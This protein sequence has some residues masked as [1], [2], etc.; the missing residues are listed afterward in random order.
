LGGPGDAWFENGASG[1]LA[2]MAAAF[3][4]LLTGA[5]GERTLLNALEMGDLSG[6]GGKVYIYIYESFS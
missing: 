1:D 4:P 5:P 3:S 6:I 2:A